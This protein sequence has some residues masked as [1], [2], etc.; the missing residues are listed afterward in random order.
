MQGTEQN[1]TQITVTY[2]LNYKNCISYK[3]MHLCTLDLISTQCS[4]DHS[5][6][7]FG[8]SC[9]THFTFISYSWL[10]FCNGCNVNFKTFMVLRGL[11]NL[12]LVIPWLP[13]CYHQQIDFFVFLMKCLNNYWVDC[14]SIWYRYSW[15]QIQIQ[16][17]PNFSIALA[18]GTKNFHI[19]RNISTFTRL[20][21]HFVQTFVVPGGWILMTLVITWLSI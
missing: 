5:L 1:I 20:V 4:K 18:E 15:F 10:S 9:V 6:K 19:L 16:M 11:I 14:H 13:L 3:K 7:A 8:L 12:T 2:L 21:Q 17:P